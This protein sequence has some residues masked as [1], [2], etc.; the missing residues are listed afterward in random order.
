MTNVIMFFKHIENSF[1]G[2]SKLKKNERKKILC[3]L[4]RIQ[5]E[6]QSTPT[7]FTR[8]N[9][10]PNFKSLQ[11]L[12]ICADKCALQ[13]CHWTTNVRRKNFPPF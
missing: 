3:E 4:K 2:E 13:N 11:I 10:A 5:A 6:V 9:T 7:G 8:Y 1:P 12:H